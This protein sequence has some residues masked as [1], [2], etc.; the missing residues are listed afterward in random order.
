MIFTALAYVAGLNRENILEG[1]CWRMKQLW[2]KKQRVIWILI[3]SWRL[4]GLWLFL[5]FFKI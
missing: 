5:I 4:S 1:G 2:S 3:L